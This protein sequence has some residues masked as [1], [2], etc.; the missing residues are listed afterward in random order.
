MNLLNH[1]AQFRLSGLSGCLLSCWLLSACNPPSETPKTAPAID[2]VANGEVVLTANSPKK[3]YIQTVTLE[4][5]RPPLLEPLVGKVAYDESV[6]TRISSPISGRVIDNP[7]PLGSKVQVGTPLLQLHSPEVADA[8]ADFAKARAQLMLA[9]QAFNRQQQLYDGKVVS[10]KDLE[11]AQDDLSQ[12][13][14]EVNR[15]ENRL[16]NLQIVAG[17][18]NARFAL[19]SPIAGTVVERNVNPGQ[20]VNPGL[21]QPLFVVSDIQ[22]LTV[23]LE[24]FEIN[25]PKIQLGQTLSLSVPAYPGEQFPAKVRYIGQVLNEATR[26]VQVRGELPNPDGRLLPGMYATINVESAPDARAIVVPLTAVF[27][28]D[29]SDYVFVAVDDNHYQQ[30]PIKM[31]L[32]LKDRAVVTEGLQAGERLVTQGALVLRA[33]EDINDAQP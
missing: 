14:S 12:A 18:N 28:E 11:Q 8:E 22:H 33:E 16:K 17:Q 31:G 6:T 30:K 20:E 7:L 4:L 27:T 2:K 26:T 5:Q 10:R 13:R 23:L 19:R 24:V 1:S 3:A 25:L 29:E 21:D 9:Q 32:R 15:L